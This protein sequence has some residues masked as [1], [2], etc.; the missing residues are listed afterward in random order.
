MH[1]LLLFH[2]K[3]VTSSPNIVLVAIDQSI[4]QLG[5]PRIGIAHFLEL[6]SRPQYIQKKEEAQTQ[7]VAPDPKPVG[8]NKR[9]KKG[10]Q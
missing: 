7:T 2:C 5:L 10:F 4:S 3:H 1:L 8:R 6:M 9:A